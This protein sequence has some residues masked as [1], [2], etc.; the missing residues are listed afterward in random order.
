MVKD[1]QIQDKLFSE[2]DLDISKVDI[3]EQVEE[4]NTIEIVSLT[5]WFQTWFNEK[6]TAFVNIKKP[7]LSLRNFNEN[8][9]LVLLLSETTDDGKE[10]SRLIL[11]ND[12]HVTPV[13]NLPPID[14]QIYNSNGFRIIYNLDN[15][16]VYLKT[17]RVRKGLVVVSC[18][19]YEELLI[20]LTITKVRK[21][22]TEMEK[23]IIDPSI[24]RA[25]LSKKVDIEAL[26]LRYRQSARV[27]G[28]ETNLDAV[29]W[30]LERQA[31]IEDTNH[32]I[33]IDNVIIDTLRSEPVVV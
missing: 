10:E 20:P 12:A 14:M 25:N 8:K 15:G 23:P 9:Q 33:Q 28:L 30:L 18:Y 26:Q 31:F 13:L 32:H 3:P 19:E 17:Y 4:N 7:T 1:G 6:S 11:F 5:D 2:V 29:K 21:R 27:Q 22:D 16:S 24:S